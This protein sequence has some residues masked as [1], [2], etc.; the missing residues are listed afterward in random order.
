MCAPVIPLLAAVGGA[1]SIA[2]SLGILGGGRNQQASAG[3]QMTAPPALKSPGP[4][5]TGAV[6]P[7]ELKN[8]EDAATV[9]QNAKQLRD[10]Q[11][12]KKGLQGLGAKPA[13]NTPTTTPPTGINIG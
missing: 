6:K 3:R 8:E 11:T 10:K 2:S 9:K 12:V 7:E 1:A 5:A 4:A 13:I